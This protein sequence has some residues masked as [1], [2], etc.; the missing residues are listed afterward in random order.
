[1][2]GAGLK[3]TDGDVPPIALTSLTR[4]AFLAGPAKDERKFD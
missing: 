4:F 1:M 3:G 2:G